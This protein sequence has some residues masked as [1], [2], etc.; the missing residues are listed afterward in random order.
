MNKVSIVVPIYNAEKFLRRCLDSIINQT[1][2]NIEIILID[3]G[4]NDNSREICELYKKE[5]NRIIV[6]HN[7]NHGVSYTRNCGIDIAQGKYILFIDSDDTVEI[8]YVELLVSAIESSN[9]DI[10]VCAY[11]DI[12]GN[13]K[14]SNALDDDIVNKLTGDI[15]NDYFDL[16][17]FMYH[18]YEKIYLLDVIKKYNIYFLNDRTVAEDQCF[19]RAYFGRIHSIIFVNKSLY[20]YYHQN[21][22]SLTKL[23]TRKTFLDDME[24]FK[25][26]KAFLFELSIKKPEI[27]LTDMFILMLTKYICIDNKIQSYKDYSKMIKEIKQDIFSEYKSDSFKRR[28]LIKFAQYDCFFPIYI[29]YAMKFYYRK[30]R[31]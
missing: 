22:L 27:I 2:K 7:D 19:N 17:K 5:D 20:N 4:S 10:A 6:R 30:C 31:E 3:D 21:N 18:P 16:N 29:Y 15:R 1:Y 9:K 8:N 12:Y 23:R 25:E 13:K 14:I 26:L 24:N 11:N 28:I